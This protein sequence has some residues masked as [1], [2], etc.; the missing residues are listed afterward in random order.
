MLQFDLLLLLDNHFLVDEL[1]LWYLDFALYNFLDFFVDV[2]VLVNR[3]IYDLVYVYYFLDDVLMFH[4]L[5][6]FP[7]D[8][9]LYRPRLNLSFL[10]DRL[11][12]RHHFRIDDIYILVCFVQ[13]FHVIGHLLIIFNFEG[14]YS[15]FEPCLLLCICRI[16]SRCDIVH[17][18]CILVFSGGLPVLESLLGIPLG[19]SDGNSLAK[20]VNINDFLNFFDYRLVNI[21]DNFYN[22]IDEFWHN[23]L[24]SCRLC[25][26]RIHNP[27]YR[28]FNSFLKVDVSW[29]GLFYLFDHLLVNIYGRLCVRKIIVFWICNFFGWLHWPF[30]VQLLLA[31]LP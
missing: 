4:F 1:K 11:F 6:F 3:L 23:L 19:R 13:N 8:H 31:D 2:L 15:S 14:I 5:K 9:S 29:D 28:Y 17:L 7:F 30:F 26:W 10:Y 22:F 12:D 16:L 24:L 25:W 21:L 18:V 20:L 27:F